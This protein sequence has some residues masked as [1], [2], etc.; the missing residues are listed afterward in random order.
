MSIVIKYS[1]R[2]R[3]RLPGVFIRWTLLVRLYYMNIIIISDN[4]SVT[5]DVWHVKRMTVLPM[6]YGP[7][8]KSVVLID[9]S[10]WI[11]SA[12][13]CHI[14][15]R[16][17]ITYASIIVFFYNSQELVLSGYT[18]SRVNAS[19]LGALEHTEPSYGWVKCI[20]C[21]NM[22][23]KHMYLVSLHWSH[24]KATQFFHRKLYS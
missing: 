3:Y 17:S 9:S 16:R 2:R 12:A 8:A 10:K 5:R 23:S 11:T 18:V 4:Y 13:C 21:I 22:F 1:S 14:Y 20:A 15:R 24:T 19:E 6:Y 7:A